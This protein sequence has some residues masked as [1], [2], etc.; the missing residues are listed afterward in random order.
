MRHRNQC[1]TRDT[2]GTLAEPCCF[3]LRHPKQFLRS[4]R[5]SVHK[6]SPLSSS[7]ASLRGKEWVLQGGGRTDATH[8][9]HLRFRRP[10]TI[11][12]HF[13]DVEQH[14]HTKRMISKQTRRSTLHAECLRR[15]HSWG[16]GSSCS[17]CL[18]AGAAH[19]QHADGQHSQ[20]AGRSIQ[21]LQQW[22][23][24]SALV[25]RRLL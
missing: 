11:R 5:S 1:T 20:V 7:R 6:F 15:A 8:W 22:V 10:Q 13:T 9:V 14:G 17:T 18:A 4:I 16:S 12:A 19:L 23:L 2:S 24:A 3:L 21:Q 25:H